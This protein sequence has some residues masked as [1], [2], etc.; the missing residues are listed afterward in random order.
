MTDTTTIPPHPYFCDDCGGRAPFTIPGCPI[1]HARLCPR[2]A[3][4]P[5][6]VYERAKAYC[7]RTGKAIS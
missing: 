7:Q 1:A 4:D 6:A 5:M 3:E 2:H